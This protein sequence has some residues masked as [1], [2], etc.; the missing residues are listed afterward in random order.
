MYGEEFSCFLST[1]MGSLQA[2]E[3][4]IYKLS[5]KRNAKVR[6]CGKSVYCASFFVECI[7]YTTFSEGHRASNFQK[8]FKCDHCLF[9]FGLV[10]HTAYFATLSCSLVKIQES[11]ENKPWI[12]AVSETLIF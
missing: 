2:K 4:N 11:M 3:E 1:E 9:I 6:N 7:G 12:S 8:S 10:Y 5:Q